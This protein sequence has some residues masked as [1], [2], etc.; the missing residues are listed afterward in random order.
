MFVQAG[1]TALLAALVFL[2]D[3][4]YAAPALMLVTLTGLTAGGAHGFVYPGLAALV[5]DQAPEARRAPV[6]GVFSAMWLVGQTGGAVAFGYVAHGLGYELTW[7]MLTACLAVGS[8]LSV[9]LPP[10]KR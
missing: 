5:A 2:S 4:G 10:E 9:G 7:T 8:V 3:F 6:I 1:G